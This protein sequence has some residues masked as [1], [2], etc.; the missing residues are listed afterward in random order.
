MKF[1]AVLLGAGQ[2]FIG[3]IIRTALAGLGG[4][5]IS[6]GVDAGAAND[7]VTAIGGVVTVFLAAL[8]SYLNNKAE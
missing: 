7:L 6:K 5:L 1:L 2:G 8:G 4:W 3:T